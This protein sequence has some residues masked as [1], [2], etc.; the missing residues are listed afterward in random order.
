MSDQPSLGS[1]IPPHRVFRVVVSEDT[2]A[3]TAPKLNER[4]IM[5]HMMSIADESGV[6]IFYTYRVQE[7]PDTAGQ[8]QVCLVQ[9]CTHVFAEWVEAHELDVPSGTGRAH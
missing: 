7:L 8:I 6:L 5:A 2:G 3:E 9:Y 1:Q 4:T